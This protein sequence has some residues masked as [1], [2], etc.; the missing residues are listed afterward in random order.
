VNPIVLRGYALPFAQSTLLAGS[1]TYERF[2]A[3]AFDRLLNRASPV[4]IR[5]GSHNE[6]APV[7]ARTSDGT[8]GLFADEFGL[9]FW[10]RVDVDRHWPKVREITQ[11]VNPVDRCSVGGLVIVAS[12]QDRCLGAPRETVSQAHIDHIAI[13]DYSA[14]YK[15]TGVWPASHDLEMAPLRVQEMAARWSHGHAQWQRR[16]NLIARAERIAN[17]P[18]EGA[19]GDLSTAQLARVQA[20]CRQ[21]EAATLATATSARGY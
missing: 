9:G 21:I 17:G 14:A 15:S 1:C 6:D 3:T 4:A 11:R 10:A 8:A 13:V 12:D 18:G 16:A 7:L 20:I 19:D 2:A 5:W